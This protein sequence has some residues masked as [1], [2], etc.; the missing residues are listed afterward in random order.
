[1]QRGRDACEGGLEFSGGVDA[2]GAEG[3]TFIAVGAVDDGD[4]D[5]L[6]TLELQAAVVANE[7]AV[8]DRVCV[9][10]GLEGG[11]EDG[12][13][14]GKRH[15]AEALQLVEGG[16]AVCLRDD[17]VE[18]RLVEL[19][20]VLGAVEDGVAGFHDGGAEE[21]VVAATVGSELDVLKVLAKSG[22]ILDGCGVLR[23]ST[24]VKSNRDAS[25]RFSPDGHLARIASETCNV[26]LHPMQGEALVSE[27]NVC[28]ALT[29]DLIGV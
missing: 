4:A 23:C 19:G 14:L 26:L 10:V 2:P 9:A 7:V 1:M 3:G 13:E 15:I 17:V 29:Y 27:A 25:S 5:E 20:T 16:G 11:V 21:L 18:A 6:A 24:Y 8:D 28:Q 12:V 22:F